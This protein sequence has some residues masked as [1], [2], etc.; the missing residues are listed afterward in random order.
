MQVESLFVFPEESQQHAYL[1]S[2]HSVL[3]RACRTVMYIL[4]ITTVNREKFG[5]K[6]PWALF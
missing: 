5:T 3:M 1:T 4:K 6:W 2:K